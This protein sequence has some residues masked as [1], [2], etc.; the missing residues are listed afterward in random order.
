MNCGVGAEAS[1]IS[2]GAARAISDVGDQTLLTARAEV[3]LGGCPGDCD[4]QAKKDVRTSD[5][6]RNWAGYRTTSDSKWGLRWQLGGESSSLKPV[7]LKGQ[8]GCM[9]CKKELISHL[10]ARVNIP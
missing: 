6:H 4:K 5:E 9:E 7:Y 3:R 2:E 1:D 10:D 8:A